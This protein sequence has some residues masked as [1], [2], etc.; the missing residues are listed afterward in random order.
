MYELTYK[1]LA[2]PE[3]SNDD[4][5][6]ILA[7]AQK[8]NLEYGITGCLVFHNHHFIQILEGDK[9]FVKTT[10][11][12]IKDDSRHTSV[13]VLSEGTKVSRFFPDWNMAYSNPKGSE[14]ESEEVRAYA[15]NLLLLSDFMDKPTTTLKMFWTGIS[16][17]IE[18][19]L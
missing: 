12:K 10:F 5:V 19:T 2:V 17:L 6:N 14:S 4:I 9:K 13:Q 1:S 3:T 8:F 11:S 15:N 7:T 16:R 18:N